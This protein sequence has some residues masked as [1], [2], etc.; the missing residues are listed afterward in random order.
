MAQNVCTGL[1][2][3]LRQYNISSSSAAFLDQVFDDYCEQG[4]SANSKSLGL[5][6][7]VVVKAIPLKFKGT[8]SDNKSAFKNF[9]SNYQSIRVASTN[10]DIYERKITA[11]ALAT[12]DTCLRYQASNGVVM[13]HEV[14]SLR[15]IDFYLTRSALS[16]LKI[17]GVRV[18]PNENIQCKGIVDGKSVLFDE[19]SVVTVDPKQSIVCE[20]TPAKLSD[21]SLYYDEAV[22]TIQ[23]TLDNYSVFL[24]KETQF[25]DNIA[26]QISETISELAKGVGELDARTAEFKG[27]ERVQLYQCPTVNPGALGGGAW[28]YYG[29]QGQ[30]TSTSQCKTM[31]FPKEVTSECKPVQKM[32]TLP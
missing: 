15:A 1:A 2:S 16:P 10:E 17:D 8:S 22:I 3:T 26:S 31:E 13:T 29:C 11:E 30:L 12:V 4:G 24:P 25:P 27:I 14:R 19:S 9:C 18:I 21:G 20:R 32:I 23:T 7:D 28:G 5:D 6:L